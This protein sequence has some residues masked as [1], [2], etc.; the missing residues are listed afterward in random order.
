[1]TRVKI[2]GITS[3]SAF[4]AVVDGGADWLAFNFFARSP[5]HVTAAEAAALSVRHAGGPLRVGLFVAPTDDDVARAL[6]A[7]P[8]DILQLYAPAPRVAELRARFGLPVWRAVGVSATHDLPGDSDGADALLI[9]AKAPQSATRPG[10]NAA[11]LDWG[12]LSGWR[13]PY[14]WLLAGGLTPLNVGEAINRSGAVAVDVSSGVESA[15]GVKD[16]ELI[17]AFIAAA[18]SG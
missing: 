10:G 1:V 9:E 13:P 3:P 15:P 8:L 12:L 6:D 14:A 7:V 4:D 11:S 5:R 17:R 18:R 16:P 2:C